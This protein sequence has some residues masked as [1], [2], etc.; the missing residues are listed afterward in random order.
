MR[1]ALVWFATDIR[2][3]ALGRSERDMGG[4]GTEN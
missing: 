3:V 2:C 4:G 1:A